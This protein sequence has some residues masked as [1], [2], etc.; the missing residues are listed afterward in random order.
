[1]SDALLQARAWALGRSALYQGDCYRLMRELPAEDDV[2]VCMI[3]P[4]YCSGGMVRGDRV[5]RTATEKYVQNGTATRR[6]DFSGDTRD[7]RGFLAWATLWLSE[8]HRV[9][10]R[11]G[12]VMM[13]TDWRQL[14]IMS[15]ALQ[16]GGWV[17]RGI[18]PWD[19]TE[20]TRPQRGFFRAQCE[21]VL[22][23]SK[24]GLGKEQNRVVKKCAPGLFRHARDR[25]AR[26]HITGKPVA[27]IE[28]LLQVMPPRSHMLVPF[29]GS[30]SEMVAGLRCGHRVTGF[31]DSAEYIAIARDR[32]DKTVGVAAAGDS[33]P[34]ETGEAAAA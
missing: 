29:A 28:D 9:T 2:D 12:L 21:Y 11:G 20:G 16:A 3:D 14:P 19:K 7:Q 30:G 27:L 22:L 8:C 15:D 25:A 5:Q 32:L 18:A 23:G 31:E 17:W 13:F 6:P 33:L 4:P 10:K 1:M 26:L 34:L 24:G